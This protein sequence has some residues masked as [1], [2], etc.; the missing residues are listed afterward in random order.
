MIVRC[1]MCGWDG[2][3]HQYEVWD[4]RDT[5]PTVWICDVCCVDVLTK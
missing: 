3:I 2:H 5:F 1:A 4:R